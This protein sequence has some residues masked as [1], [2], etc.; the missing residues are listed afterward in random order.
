MSLQIVRVLKIGKE[1]VKIVYSDRKL[2]ERVIYRYQKLRFR[3]NN[4][5]PPV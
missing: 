5:K 4:G 1:V 3:L 2:P